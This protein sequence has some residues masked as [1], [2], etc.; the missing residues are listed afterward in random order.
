[1]GAVTGA[2][3]VAVKDVQAGTTVVGVPVETVKFRDEN[4]GEVNV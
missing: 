2:G 3:A 4:K 1:M